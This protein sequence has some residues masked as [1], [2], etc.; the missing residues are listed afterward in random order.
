MAIR[1]LQ[2]RVDFCL[3]D[4]HRSVQLA[5]D[6]G[7]AFEV[8][9]GDFGEFGGKFSRPVHLVRSIETRPISLHIRIPQGGGVAGNT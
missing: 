8:G 9:V 3:F 4:F 1:L 2:R 7:G 5:K 6:W